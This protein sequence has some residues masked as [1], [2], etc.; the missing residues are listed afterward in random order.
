MKILRFS[1]LAAILILLLIL[2]YR[3]FA[4][5]ETFGEQTRAEATYAKCQEVEKYYLAQVQQPLPQVSDPNSNSQ[6]IVAQGRGFFWNQPND[7]IFLP[8]EEVNVPPILALAQE[9]SYLSPQKVTCDLNEGKI[10]IDMQAFVRLEGREDP[11]VID[12][13]DE[14]R[15]DESS[16]VFKGQVFF[17]T[18]DDGTFFQLD[19]D[20]AFRGCNANGGD[21]SSI[22]ILSPFPPIGGAA[23]TDLALAN[24]GIEIENPREIAT[25]TIYNNNL[26]YFRDNPRG[27]EVVVYERDG[28]QILGIH[29]QVVNDVW[30]EVA[31]QDDSIFEY[32]GATCYMQ[33][34]SDSQQDWENRD[35]DTELCSPRE[36]IQITESSHQ[37]SSKGA[38]TIAPSMS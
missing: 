3:F 32:R 2:G 35:F 30:I 18:K 24:Y 14:I 26:N 37:D 19:G 20:F 27:S 28:E 5:S 8:S 10:T 22:D 38:A 16:E 9:G 29:L 23:C 13:V 7:V 15:W 31:Y 12:Q 25:C 17:S 6:L 33:Y 36:V 1:F 21:C 11:F 34:T 4:T